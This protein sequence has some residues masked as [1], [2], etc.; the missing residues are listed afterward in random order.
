MMDSKEY[1]ELKDMIEAVDR[2]V[3]TILT[4]VG[5]ISMRCKAC[6]VDNP[7]GRWRALGRALSALIRF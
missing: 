1:L 5:N 7:P 6:I 3:Q 2:K 4:S